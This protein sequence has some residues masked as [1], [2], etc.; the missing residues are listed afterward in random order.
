MILYQRA[1]FAGYCLGQMAEPDPSRRLADI[2][3]GAY[4]EGNASDI[5]SGCLISVINGSNHR[6]E[7]SR[8]AS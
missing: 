1:L 2:D 4:Q 3:W 7:I 5:A 8:P 6:L